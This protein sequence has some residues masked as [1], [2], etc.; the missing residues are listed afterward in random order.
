M[1]PNLITLKL[2]CERYS[3]LLRKDCWFTVVAIY[4]LQDNF[5]VF[6]EKNKKPKMGP[7]GLFEVHSLSSSPLFKIL[8]L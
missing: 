4:Q 3:V 6:L 5:F 8:F 1:L 7:T 2:C